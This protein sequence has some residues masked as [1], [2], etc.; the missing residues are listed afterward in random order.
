MQIFQRVLLVTKPECCVSSHKHVAHGSPLQAICAGSNAKHD[1]LEH[2][3]CAQGLGY[4]RDHPDGAD[5]KE[6][7]CV[8]RTAVVQRACVYV[9][10][11]GDAGK[12]DHLACARTSQSTPTTSAWLRRLPDAPADVPANFS[13]SH[14]PAVRQL[15]LRSGRRPASP[16]THGLPSQEGRHP[17][18]RCWL[19]HQQRTDEE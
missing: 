12:A 6:L 10:L 2:Y 4:E 8:R 1:T 15:R 19:R 17:Q 16:L 18:Q 9:Q 14:R 5:P 11:R 3:D 13:G 7:D